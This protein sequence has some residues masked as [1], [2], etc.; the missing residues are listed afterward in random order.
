MA[1]QGNIFK[2]LVEKN[3]RRKDRPIDTSTPFIITGQVFI[4]CKKNTLAE[5]H[6]KFVFNFAYMDEFMLCIPA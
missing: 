4:P 1:I 2:R 6:T 5:T 3:N